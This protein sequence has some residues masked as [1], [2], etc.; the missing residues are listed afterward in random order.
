MLDDATLTAALGTETARVLHSAHEAA[1]EM[2]ANAEAE[3]DRLL[4]ERP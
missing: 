1:A 4:T 2:V 3:A